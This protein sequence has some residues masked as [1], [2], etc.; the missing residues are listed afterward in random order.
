MLLVTLESN[1]CV[2]DGEFVILGGVANAIARAKGSS[3]LLDA[4]RK[5]FSRINAGVQ[6]GLLNPIDPENLMPLSRSDYGNG[7]VSFD[8][9]VKW[10][11][12]QNPSMQFIFKDDME[13]EQPL[14]A[15]HQSV[16][17]LLDER[18][19]V[20]ADIKRWEA[21]D[22]RQPSETLIKEKELEKLRAR[23]A[24][25]EKKIRVLRGD[26]LDSSEA[27]Q[28]VA[29]STVLSQSA[30]L[31]STKNCTPE[32]VHM[33]YVTL[34]EAVQIIQSK[35][36]ID[37]SMPQL[38]RVAAV[39]SLPLCV[40]L[41]V[42]CYSPTHSIRR[43]KK[44]EEL[45]PNY[46]EKRETNAKNDTDEVYAYGLFILPPRHVFSYQTKNT[47]R[48]DYVSSLDGQDTYC[49]GLDVS[50]DALQL[51]LK[52]LDMFITYVQ[53]TQAAP[54]VAVVELVETEKAGPIANW[55]MQ[56]QAEA[57]AFCLKLRQSGASPT[58]RSILDPMAKWC[59]DNNVK[60]DTK[61]FPSANYLRTHVLGGK[62]WDVPN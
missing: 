35:T 26:Y 16:Q 5:I 51:T 61:I 52:H 28:S 60:T 7:I 10:G 54:V 39:N 59:R 2:N 6:L 49:P 9:V 43:E 44:N 42:K 23:L 25:L 62:H 29:S 11:H 58:K 48:I 1:D 55:K 19:K 53:A 17:S 12:T 50:R 41:D 47:V 4:E 34:P 31:E 27:P 15:E 33:P 38:I 46:R 45:E 37:I 56:I 3:N 57:T 30:S 14:L 8:E 40:L 32:G 24:E 21:K 18:D 36:G 13:L 20:K 22:E